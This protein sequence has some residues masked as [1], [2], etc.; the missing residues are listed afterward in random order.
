[1]TVAPSIAVGT[2][3][4]GFTVDAVDPEK[5]K[6]MAALLRDPNPIHIDAG[7]V[8]ALGLGERVINQGPSNLSYVLTMVTRWAGGVSALRDVRMRFLGNV[9][10]GDRVECAGT[11]TAVDPVTGRAELD[12]RATVE[13][14]TV[15]QG[16]VVVAF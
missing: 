16:T 7:S 2:E 10:G 11:V 3:L 1:M 6:L 4:P 14:R 12:V 15:L 9:F 5:M 8:A 13:G